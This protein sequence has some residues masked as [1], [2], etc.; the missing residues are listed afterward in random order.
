MVASLLMSP[1][2]F[3]SHKGQ[4]ASQLL[5]LFLYNLSATRIQVAN[6][7]AHIA[8]LVFVLRYGLGFTY[9]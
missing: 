2:R 7:T 1:S 5:S 6:S 4:V 8:C 3:R 9:L